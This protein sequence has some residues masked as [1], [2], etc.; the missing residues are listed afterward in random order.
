[1]KNFTISELGNRPDHLLITSPGS[2]ASVNRAHC[3][4]LTLLKTPLAQISHRVLSSAH[5]KHSI[6]TASF[7]AI[8]ATHSRVSPFPP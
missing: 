1:M 5:Q 3:F 8:T 6:T 2:F 4:R 7:S